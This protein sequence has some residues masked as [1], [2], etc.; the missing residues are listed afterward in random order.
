MKTLEQTIYMLMEQIW[1]GT[2]ATTAQVQ[3]LMLILLMEYRLA[4]LLIKMVHILSLL[5]ILLLKEIGG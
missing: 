1:F 3:D 2:Q 4:V 5:D